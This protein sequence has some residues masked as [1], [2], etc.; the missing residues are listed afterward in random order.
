[1]QKPIYFH[2][3]QYH[4]A[5]NE[6]GRLPAGVRYRMAHAAMQ[7]W[8]GRHFWLAE[9]YHDA[10]HAFAGVVEARC[11]RPIRI[12]VHC[13]H[14]DVIWAYLLDGQVEARSQHPQH[15]QP[16]IRLSGGQ[17]LP[18]YAAAGQYT[19]RLAPGR[20]FLFY[21]VV[22]LSW[23]RRYQQDGLA[24]L[25]PLLQGV[26]WGYLPGQALPVR[27]RHRRLLLHLRHLEQQGHTIGQ[28]VALYP[29]LAQLVLHYVSELVP[30]DGPAET[31]PGAKVGEIT[32]YLHQ[33]VP[34]GNIPTLADLSHGFGLSERGLYSLFMQ[35]LHTTPGRYIQRVRMEEAH[36]LLTRERLT[37]TAVAY[38]L[39]YDHLRTF[40][41][42][43]KKYFGKTPREA[44][45]S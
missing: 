5:A 37:P 6:P 7:R 15:G 33:E 13:P 36:R 16:P 1:M 20:H 45:G 31:S 39:G 18:V 3:E 14:G 11:A 27:Y 10:R 17:Y 24:A 21:F 29:P 32:A 35:V 42:A 9:Q 28:D 43:F 34:Q 4:R 44:R 8:V 23:L 40:E 19:L 26:Q 30:S 41:R 12:A 2:P 38:Q 25:G 22:Q